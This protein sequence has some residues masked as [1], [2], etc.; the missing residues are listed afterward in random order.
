SIDNDSSRDLDQA[1]VADRVDGGIRVRIA[2]ADV[3]E[4][5]PLG[6]PI[7]QHAAEQTTSVYTGV[8]TFAMLPEQLS[9]NL[10]SL[11]EGVDRLAIVI[12]M[13]VAQDGAIS[14]T[15]VYRALVRNQAQ[16]TYNG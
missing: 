12:E 13:L 7:D 9:T 10:T 1:E 11:N 4:D 3:D 16:L 2:I 6:S 5:V 14:S 15:S 8:R